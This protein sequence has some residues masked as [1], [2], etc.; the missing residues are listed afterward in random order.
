MASTREIKDRINSIQDTRKITN[1]MYLIS[2]T[3][4]RRARKNLE[5]T[6]PYFYSIQAM[7]SRML[8]H[9]PDPDHPFFNS[10]D[11]LSEDE[12]V[13]GYLVITADKG[14]AG[15][16]NHN[17]LKMTMEALERRK[18]T[19]LFVVGETGRHFFESK[20]IPI[21]EEF[22]YTAQNPSLH[23]ARVISLKLLELYRA[24]SLHELYIVFTSMKDMMN[25]EVQSKQLLPL[26]STPPKMIV[27][28][29]VHHEEFALK[30]SLDA[31]VEN[32]V[33]NYI[34]G[35]IYSALVESFCSEQ[36]SRMLSMKAANS[37]A[38]DILHDLSVKH[39]RIR[40]AGITQEITE[41]VGGAKALK[42]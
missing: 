16:Y 42:R 36:N 25:A 34:M 41:V 23:R 1:A 15:A 40:Q 18:N 35:F 37:A 13:A 2:S 30:P 14:L 3:K 26:R 27:P 5:A 20:G 38:S 9:I 8:R 32:V 19:M 21:D 7:M 29:G 24:G 39:N 11:E 28:A 10:H 33:P 17:V 22:H 12:K 4:L 31:V 6:E